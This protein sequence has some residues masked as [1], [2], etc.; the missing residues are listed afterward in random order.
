[1]QNLHTSATPTHRRSKVNDVVAGVYDAATLII[2]QSLQ[3][4]A[5]VHDVRQ[6]RR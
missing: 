3:T 5:F 1:M 4:S 2:R 6:A